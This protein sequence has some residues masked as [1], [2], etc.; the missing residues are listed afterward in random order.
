MFSFA[1]IYEPQ[2]APMLPGRSSAAGSAL[3]PGERAESVFKSLSG[4]QPAP[5]DGAVTQQAAVQRLV[6]W[7]QRLHHL[8]WIAVVS[9]GTLPS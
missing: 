8:R 6:F 2:S 9:H 5:P 1:P 3:L 4:W 7:P